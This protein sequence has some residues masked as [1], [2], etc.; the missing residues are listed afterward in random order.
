MTEKYYEIRVVIAVDGADNEQAFTDVNN[1]LKLTVED[2]K[3]IDYN[4]LRVI[5]VTSEVSAR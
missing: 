2:G 5:D 4:Y 1:T 3:I